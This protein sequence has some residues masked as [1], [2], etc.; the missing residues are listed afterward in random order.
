LLSSSTP[1]EPHRQSKR[2]GRGRR[3]AIPQEQRPE[4]VCHSGTC[5]QMYAQAER[6]PFIQAAMPSCE[7][8]HMCEGLSNRCPLDSIPVFTPAEREP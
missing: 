3:G 2:L 4:G 7:R 1:V 5:A 6:A 8:V